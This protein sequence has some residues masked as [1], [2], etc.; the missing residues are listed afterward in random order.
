MTT[1]ATKPSASQALTA[2]IPVELAGERLDRA[3]AGLFPNYSRTRIKGWIETGAVLVDG[4]PARPRDA[5]RGGEKISL[6]VSAASEARWEAQPL[7]LDI[8]H[9]DE[10]LIVV[11]KPAGIVVHPGAGNLDRTLANAL[12]AFD[13]GLAS[14]PRA[15]IV[16]RLD[17]DT[18]GLLVVARTPRAHASLIRQL[19]ART[20]KREYEAVVHGVLVA[21]STIC[22][23]IGR[24]PRERTKMAVVHAGR[25]AVTHYR[26]VSRYR[27]HTHV[28]VNLET[29]RTH[30]IRVHMAHIGHP[31]LGDPIYGGRLR[32]PGGA[33]ES[34]QATLRGFR[35]QALHASGLS[36]IHPA[37]GEEMAWQSAL[38]ADMQRLLAALKTDQQVGDHHR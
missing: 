22:A 29:G 16:H 25:Q 19:Q 14:L 4:Q 21:G 1:V 38:P 35:R 28:R 6:Q 23:P 8:V 32:M 34:L 26:V 20:V 33:G 11:N 10:E 7:V 37:S 31:L 12:L 2:V 30:Q 17:K 15:G 13:S 3:L 5:V 18:S 9:Q 27:T 36:L 24:H